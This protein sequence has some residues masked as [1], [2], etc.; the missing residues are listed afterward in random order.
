MRG[1]L[2]PVAVAESLT[3]PCEGF[4]T[5]V[6]QPVPT[7]PF[8][9][10]GNVVPGAPASASAGPAPRASAPAMTAVP[11]PRRTLSLMTFPF[12][13]DDLSIVVLVMSQACGTPCAA[14]MGSG[15]VLSSPGGK[16]EL[17]FGQPQAGAVSEGVAGWTGQACRFEGENATCG[18]W[19]RA[20]CGFMLLVCVWA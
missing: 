17:A 13:F 3:L 1:C 15:C 20:P 14:T 18:G 6:V 12:V 4:E 19:Q 16:C 5:S 2:M 10:S 7:L 9:C 8:G 11:T